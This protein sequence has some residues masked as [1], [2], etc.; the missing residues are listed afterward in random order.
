M[1]LWLCRGDFPA[2]GVSVVRRS[3]VHPVDLKVLQLLTF[4]KDDVDLIEV[5][6][7]F[8]TEL[9]PGNDVFVETLLFIHINL[10]AICCG[11]ISPADK[12]TFGNPAV[13]LHFSKDGFCGLCFF[14]VGIERNSWADRVFAAH[15]AEA[16][17]SQFDVHVIG[18]RSAGFLKFVGRDFP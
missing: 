10:I 7:F 12:E 5:F 2:G 16:A 14:I 11:C 15:E 1:G 6:S 9:V 18:G 17:G 8:R 13:V 3:A 4:A